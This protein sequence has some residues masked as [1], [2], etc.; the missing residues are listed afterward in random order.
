MLC[1]ERPVWL[2]SAMTW[3]EASVRGVRFPP[4][5]LEKSAL[6]SWLAAD[7]VFVGRGGDGSMMGERP[8]AQEALFY[9]FSLARHVPSGHLLRS[10]DR[11]VDL[12]S[13]RKHLRPF[14]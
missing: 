6:K 9:G 8:T 3:G 14:Y 2:R 10:I 5:A 7:S 11:F 1:A 12:A 13:I 4:I